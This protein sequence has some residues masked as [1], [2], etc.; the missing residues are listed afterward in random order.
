MSTATLPATLAPTESGSLLPDPSADRLYRLSVAQYQRMTE[1]GILTPDDR[2]ELLDGLLVRKMSKNAPHIAATRLLQRA[3]DQN[4]PPGWMTSKE[5]P[6]SLEH[7][8]PEPDV[9]VLR[10]TL[11]EYFHRKPGPDDVSLA[12]EVADATYNDDRQK[13]RLYAEAGIVR[14]WIVNLPQRR[15]E[16]YSDP[17]GADPAPDYRTRR[18][19]GPNDEITLVLEGREIARLAVRNLLPPAE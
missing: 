14:S 13:I 11:E 6:I 7:S 3:L 1:A 8:E 19:Y 17:T 12:I 5:D 18:E 9:A 4:L 2:V 10:G 15:I 16:E